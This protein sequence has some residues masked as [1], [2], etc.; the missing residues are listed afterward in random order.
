VSPAADCSATDVVAMVGDVPV[1]LANSWSIRRPR[2]FAERLSESA[3]LITG[4][5]ILD[6]LFPLA[7]GS[8]AAVP[9]GF[10]TGKTILLQQ[11][12]KWCDADVIVY[13]GCGERGNELADTLEELRALVDPRTGRP[14]M[15]RTVIIANTS[16]MP[17]MAREVSVYTGVAVAEYYRDLGYD[18]VVIADSTSRWAEALR[19]FASRQGALPVEEGYP[20]ELASNLAAF[21]ERAG[22]VRTLAG[23]EASVTIIGA[24][25][26]PGGDRTEPVTS[27]TRR[28][29]RTCWSLDRDLAAARRYPAIGWRD[30]F[31]RDSIL[32][33]GWYTTHGAPDWARCRARAM[34][35]LSNADRLASV[36]EL[37]GAGALP[38]RERVVLLAA[39]LLRDAVLVQSAVSPNDAFCGVD[40]QAALLDGV[41]RIYDRCLAL[42]AGGVPA[43]LIEE[44]DI[45]EFARASD[46]VGPNDAEAVRR[47]ADSM[48][49]RLGAVAP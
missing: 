8:T 9:G 49:E 48:L 41:L 47:I 6:L 18:T 14:L 13:V 11:I 16:N 46:E 23:S 28:F 42:I 15:E 45:S 10:G 1:A 40:K 26:P 7:R 22:R 17:V 44:V 25:S 35:L 39:D 19:E 24:V 20:A 29:V 38:D 32:L 4:Q 30:S 33:D 27:H 12:A 21:Y 37:V 43:T 3:P 31:A 2:P 5:R 34:E 36:A